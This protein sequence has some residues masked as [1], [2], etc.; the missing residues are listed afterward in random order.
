LRNVH[1]RLGGEREGVNILVLD[2]TSDVTASVFGVQ[3]ILQFLS[4]TTSDP[5]EDCER[6]EGD[7]ADTS[8][9]TTDDGTN[10]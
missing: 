6:D 1:R 9:D 4:I 5:E 3:N 8:H 7:T 2:E 10:Y